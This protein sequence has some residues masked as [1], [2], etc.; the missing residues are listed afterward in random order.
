MVAGGG[1]DA[2]WLECLWRFE[3]SRRTRYEKRNYN[4]ERRSDGKVFRWELE[5]AM[6]INPRGLGM[7]RI[8]LHLSSHSQTDTVSPTSSLV[9]TIPP[10][11]PTH[12]T[13]SSTSR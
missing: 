4:E 7:S 5:N 10:L 6:H 12:A 8:S 1:V 11:A 2:S 3:P 13:P 9:A